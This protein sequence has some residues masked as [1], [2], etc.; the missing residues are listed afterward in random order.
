MRQ[1]RNESAQARPIWIRE[2]IQDQH[3]FIL[4]VVAR[5][6][7]AATNETLRVCV[8]KAIPLQRARSLSRSLSL[9][10]SLSLYLA[11]ARAGGLQVLF[12]KFS[13]LFLGR[14]VL[15]AVARDVDGLLPVLVLR[16]GVGPSVDQELDDVGVAVA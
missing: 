7:T 10:L 15:D 3:V 16:G 12:E 14:R 13:N 5:W 1:R 9:S 6:F 11:R 8:F 4:A 2:A